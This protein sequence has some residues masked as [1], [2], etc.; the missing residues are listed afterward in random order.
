MKRETVQKKLAEATDERGRLNLDL[1]GEEAI[2]QV[3]SAYISGAKGML[4]LYS[5][6][7]VAKY[8][9]TTE[10][11]VSHC[12]DRAIIYGYIKFNQVL[13]IFK[14]SGSNE[15][16][17]AEHRGL[18]KSEKRYQGIIKERF[19]R[20]KNTF[21]EE[22]NR[23]KYDAAYKLYLGENS[24][25]KVMGTYGIS[26]REMQYLLVRKACIDMSGVEYGIFSRKFFYDFIGTVTYQK[27]VDYIAEFRK[28][29]A[30]QISVM[31]K[32]RAKNQKDSEEYKT[33]RNE[34]V[35]YFE[36]H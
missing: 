9:G 36:E 30:K 17:H 31:Q 18:T 34:L 16:R 6:E 32:A 35:R 14:N 25:Q 15:R 24:L 19:E 12:I 21:E 27:Y 4:K 13:K 7:E 8:Y 11:I 26:E 10:T 5:K 23:A 29:M 3:T 2:V 33:A 22:N 20:F 28:T 1:L